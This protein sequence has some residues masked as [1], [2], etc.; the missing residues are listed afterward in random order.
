MRVMFEPSEAEGLPYRMI[1][2]TARRVSLID[3]MHLF[4]C[5]LC[6]YGFTHAVCLKA[7]DG[8][9]ISVTF[10]ITSVGSKELDGF[11]FEGGIGGGW[12]DVLAGVVVGALW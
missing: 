6:C 3:H 8:Y 11:L 1:P 2:F 7:L 4:C 9:M 12:G 5:T 10:W